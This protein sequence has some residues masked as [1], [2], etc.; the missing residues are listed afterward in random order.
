MSL[1]DFGFTYALTPLGITNV[2][3]FRTPTG[4]PDLGRGLYLTTRDFLKFG[5]LYA[6]GG[7]WNGERIVSEAWV[8]ASVVPYTEFGWAQPETF[9]WQV[10]GYGYQWW[11]GYF[12]VDGQRVEAYAARGHGEQNLLVIPELDLVV[13][14]FSHAFNLEE[15][16]VNQTYALIA[17]HIIPAL[18]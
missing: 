4:L 17:N 3:V 1:I 7:T 18:P 12:E 9:D 2:E 14:I 10:S 5:Q 15:D 16:E 13:A 8:D 11:T 6:N